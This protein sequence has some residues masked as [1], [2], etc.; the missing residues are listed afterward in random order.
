MARWWAAGL[1]FVIIGLGILYIFTDVLRVPLLLGTL[2]ASEITIVIRYFVNDLWVFRE[3]QPSWKRFWQYHVA[4][5]L[6]FSVWWTIANVLARFGVYYLVASVMGTI[7][8]VLVSMVTNF[9]WI[10][11]STAGVGWYA[12]RDLIEAAHGEQSTGGSSLGGTL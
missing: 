6:G 9:F 3:N 5:V 11:R 10:W 4:N 1:L 2:C 8:S 12:S 7:C